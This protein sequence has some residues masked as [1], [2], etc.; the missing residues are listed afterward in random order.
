MPLEHISSN[1]SIRI[2]SKFISAPVTSDHIHSVL[3]RFLFLCIMFSANI[4]DNLGVILAQKSSTIPLITAKCGEREIEALCVHSLWQF[5]LYDFSMGK[6][7][8]KRLEAKHRDKFM[9]TKM[10]RSIRMSIWRINVFLFP[11]VHS[12]SL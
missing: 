10:R 1:F 2:T 6:A 11:C 3:A 7:M 12:Y 9:V 8:I 5:L 4:N